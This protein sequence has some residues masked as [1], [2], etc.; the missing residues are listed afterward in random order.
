[1]AF[2]DFVDD[3]LDA[4]GGLIGGHGAEGGGEV[5]E[6]GAFGGV[7]GAELLRGFYEVLVVAD[8]VEDEGVEEG[9]GAGGGFGAVAAEE[10]PEHVGGVGVDD[11]GEVE[12]HSERDRRGGAL[13]GA[14]EDVEGRV[15]A[16]GG[17]VLG[18]ELGGVGDELVDGAG[19][20]VEEQSLG[21]LGLVVHE[22]G[23]A[24]G[25]GVGQPLFDAEAVAFAFA[26]LLGLF[27]EEQL[28]G[29]ADRGAAAEN[30]ADAAG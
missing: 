5:F 1:M 2:A 24:F 3:V 8:G 25:R 19:D 7:G 23:E 26:D 21:A 18:V 12:E 29:E 13:V 15:H 28:V 16:A 27:V 11:A 20:D 22:L 30:L 6:G 14:G 17:L 4:F 9:A 10:A